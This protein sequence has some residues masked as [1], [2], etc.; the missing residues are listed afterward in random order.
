MNADYLKKLRR[1]LEKKGIALRDGLGEKQLVALEHDFGF[2]FPPDL[3]A[4]LGAFVPAGDD[5]PDW[6]D[7]HAFELIEWLD[8]PFDGI[9]FDVEENGFWRKE[10]GVRPEDT[11][12]AVEEARRQ[13]ALAPALIPVHAHRYLPARPAEAGNPVF[14]VVQTDVIVY[15]P[16]L[17]DFFAEEFGGPPGRRGEPRRIDFWS[18]LA[19]E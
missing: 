16:T 13:V 9:A 15:A 14:S 5:F 2:V 12:D 8:M 3:R 1:S 4:M 7:P 18:D 6:H 10:W 19:G 11:D 17:E